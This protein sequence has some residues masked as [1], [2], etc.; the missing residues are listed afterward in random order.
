MSQHLSPCLVTPLA[1]GSE[2]F[3]SAHRSPWCVRGV[4]VG[5]SAREGFCLTLQQRAL[6]RR[7]CAQ[8]FAVIDDALMGDCV[9]KV[10]PADVRP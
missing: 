7:D 6:S 4:A 8:P 5:Q 10:I 3:L 1:P 2:P 9:Q